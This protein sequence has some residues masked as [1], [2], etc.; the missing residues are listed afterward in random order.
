MF[1]F[2]FLFILKTSGSPN[3][4][5]WAQIYSAVLWHHKMLTIPFDIHVFAKIINQNVCSS[6]TQMTNFFWYGR[7]NYC[8]QQTGYCK[9]YPRL[10]AANSEVTACT[11]NAWYMYHHFYFKLS[12]EPCS[13]FINL[14][15]RFP[16]PFTQISRPFVFLP[17]DPWWAWL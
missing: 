13:Q 11:L 8:R 12:P 4:T 14:C 15:L 9:N 5:L 1:F 7:I 17:Y 3:Q 2:V 10:Y 6:R 16:N